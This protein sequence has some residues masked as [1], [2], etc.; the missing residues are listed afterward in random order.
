MLCEALSAAYKGSV[1]ERLPGSSSRANESKAAADSFS[2]MP[3]KVRGRTPSATAVIQALA[4]LMTARPGEVGREES[5]NAAP[6]PGLGEGEK[7]SP[8]KGARTSLN[9]KVGAFS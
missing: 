6:R 8:V 1:K 7:R 9:D 4:P 3:R 2:P 5:D